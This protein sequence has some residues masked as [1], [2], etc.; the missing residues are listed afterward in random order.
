V[1]FAFENFD[2]HA[3]LFLASENN[4]SLYSV[5]KVEPPGKV[6]AESLT[7]QF[8]RID[9]RFYLPA[10]ARSAKEGAPTLKPFNFTDLK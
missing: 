10:V 3:F 7:W 5:A 4:Q 9:E 6:K 1:Y 8:S 2:E